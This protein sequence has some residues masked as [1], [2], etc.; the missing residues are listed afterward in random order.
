MARERDPLDVLRTTF[1]HQAFRGRQ[2]EV[3]SHLIGG[4]DAVVLFPTG[5]GKSMCYQV[6]ALCRSGTGIVVSPLIALMRDQVE[7]LRQAGVNAGA[8]NSMIAPD[9]AARV[10]RDFAAGTLELLYVAPERLFSEGFLDFLGTGTIALFAID[11]AHCVSAWGHD[12]RPEYLQLAALKDRFPG[13]PRVA[14]TATADPQTRDDL[15][16]RLRLEDAP[17][18]ATSFDRPNIRYSIVEK[19]QPRRQLLQFLKPH[20]RSSGIVYCLSRK[21]VEEVA[22]FLSDNGIRALPYH[23]GLDRAVRDGNQDAFLKEDRLCLVATVAFG[24]G[25]D[26]PD[27]RYVAHMDLPGSVE[28]YYQ[29]TGRAG[30]DGAPSDAWMSYGMADV[31]QRR[32]MIDEGQSPEEVKRVERGK[33][34]ALLGIC[35]TAGCRRQALLAH[36]GEVHSGR[37]GNCDTC[38]NPVETIDGTVV[39][40]KL[41]SAIYRTGERYGAGHVIDVLRGNKTEKVA[42]AGH[43]ALPTFGVGKDRDQRSWLSAIR[44][45]SVA[46]LVQVD[47]AFGTLKLGEGARAVLR[48]ERSLE[49]RRERSGKAASTAKQPAET[50]PAEADQLFQALRAERARLARAQ[51]LPPYVVFHDTT[52]VAMATRRPSTLDDLGGIPGVGSAKLARYGAAFLAVIQDNLPL[53]V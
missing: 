51:G 26:K 28:A 4:G 25:I 46:G 5:A 32:R 14:L 30:R 2:S 8:L 37:C 38:L 27:V 52:L 21:K 47:H 35:E 6:P 45:L 7:A 9:E 10:R 42:K 20:V 18:F 34:S 16:V 22:S 31:V 17:V 36:F 44:Q 29:E 50:L 53:D 1:G 19:D 23:A 15:R 24:M 11:E 41:M 49:L 13:V 39:A 43:D 3:V 12:F 48:G 40:Q 33:L